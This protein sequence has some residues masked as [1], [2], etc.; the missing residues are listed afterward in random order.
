MK[1]IIIG[2]IVGTII[3]FAFQSVMWE[4]GFHR[5]FY[6]YTPNQ[7]TVMH[8]LARNLPKEGL[9]MMPMSDPESPDFK[10]QQEKREKAMVGNP[11]AMVFFHPKMDNFS[12]GYLLM[13]LFYTLVSVLLAALVIFYSNFPGFWSRFLVSMA[14]AAFVLAQNVFAGMNWWSFPW[15]FI[16][17]QV[18]DLIVGWGL[19]SI[20]LAWFVRKKPASVHQSEPTINT[21]TI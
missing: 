8:A 6:T 3:Y 15:S 9:Y 2:T 4:G 5:D 17:P 20:W 12:A 1:K 14:F 10:T 11:W 18:I 13:G 21:T 19:C 16:K 7:D